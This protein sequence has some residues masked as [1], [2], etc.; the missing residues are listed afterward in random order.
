MDEAKFLELVGGLISSVQK[1][2]KA[3][4]PVRQLNNMKARLGDCIADLDA[5]SR[6]AVAEDSFAALRF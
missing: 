5:M 3:G 6:D 2:L 1:A 4:V